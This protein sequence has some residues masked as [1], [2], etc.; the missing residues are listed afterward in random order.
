MIF[1]VFYVI[2][3]IKAGAVKPTSWPLVLDLL[4][5][6][7]TEKG[8]QARLINLES[9]TIEEEPMEVQ[10]PAMKT[11]YLIVKFVVKI[12]RYSQPPL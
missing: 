9:S 7:R 11:D 12:S 4:V 5:E 3:I 2:N 6:V 8:T 1:L 10:V